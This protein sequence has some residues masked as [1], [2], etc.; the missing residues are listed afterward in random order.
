MTLA[1]TGPA[2]LR[3][4][5]WLDE[6]VEAARDGIAA[7]RDIWLNWSE[8]RNV[9]RF[10]DGLSFGDFM[11]SRLGYALPLS[12]AIKALPEASN[13]QIAVVAG[14]DQST[15]YRARQRF[16]NANP[17]ASGLRVTGADGK[18]YPVQQRPTPEPQE[19]AIEEPDTPD[20]NLNAFYV[21]ALRDYVAEIVNVLPSGLVLKSPPTLFRKRH[22]LARA[23]DR[24]IDEVLGL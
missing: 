5:R 19:E 1:P 15:V 22:A 24:T 10:A 13:P 16:A 12:E 17:D 18:S 8:G 4:Q 6:H 3:D 21:K 7:A 20:D 23:L 2:D 11:R 14:V 9:S